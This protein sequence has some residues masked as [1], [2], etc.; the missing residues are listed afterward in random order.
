[1]FRKVKKTDIHGKRVIPSN[2]LF[3]GSGIAHQ[4]VGRSRIMA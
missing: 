2:C 4:G 1:M 3:L